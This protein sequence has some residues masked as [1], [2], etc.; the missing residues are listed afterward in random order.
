VGL[1][2]TIMNAMKGGEAVVLEDKGIIEMKTSNRAK[3]F[4]LAVVIAT[5]VL[6]IIF[7]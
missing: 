4:G 1:V 2:L 6:Y 5:V 3:F 7:W